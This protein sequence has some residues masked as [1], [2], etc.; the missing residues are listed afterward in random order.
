MFLELGRRK[1]LAI[2]VHIIVEIFKVD[3]LGRGG[4]SSLVMRRDE[5]E[6]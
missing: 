5:R 4:V 3:E 6:E 1:T 2:C